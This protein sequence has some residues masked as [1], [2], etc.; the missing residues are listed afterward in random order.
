MQIEADLSSLVRCVPSPKAEGVTTGKPL[1]SRPDGLRLKLFRTFGIFATLGDA[2]L[3]ALAEACT[4]RTWP[5]SV[6][7]FQRGDVEDHLLAITSGRVRL[8]LARANGQELVLRHLG[9][10]DVLGEMALID[11]QPRSADAV[12]IETTTALQLN[13]RR[14]HAIAA[15]RPDVWMAVAKYLC[16][17]LRNTNF[18]MES[19]AL[20]DLKLRIIR[21]ILLALQQGH[22]DVIP[23]SAKLRLGLNQTDLSSVL[24]ASRPKVNQ[25]LQALIGEGVLRRDGSTLVCDVV[26]LRSMAA[27]DEEAGLL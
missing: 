11:G 18:Q 21:F 16:A 9:P 3:A 23:A 12:T 19:I 8:S 22:G 20:Y 15:E 10:G 6:T 1:Q 2:S 27:A 25:A 24:G 13:R 14:F 17:Q 26:A 7:V 5:A 4:S